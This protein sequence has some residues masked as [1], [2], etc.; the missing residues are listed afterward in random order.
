V[1]RP[2]TAESLLADLAARRTALTSL[3]ARAQV[4]SG[5]RG[6]WAREAFAVRRPDAVRIDVLAPFGVALALGAQGARLWAYRP[7]DATRYDGAATA[8][9]LTRLL[10]VP[11]AVSDVVDIL[12]GLPPQRRPAGP[13]TLTPTA[14]GEYKL[15]V[16]HA[17]GA[18]TIWFAGDTLA[19]LRAEESGPHGVQ[20]RLVFSDY[21]AGFPYAI[22]LAAVGTAEARL[23][24]EAVEPNAAVD[25][26]LFVPP[27][28]PRVLPFEA[29]GPP[30]G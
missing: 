8:D 13:A 3:R 6:L 26:A 14:A 5:L 28:A 27:P 2:A 11:L 29:A 10:G 16:P 12:L 22:E 15:Q 24:Y 9:N 21:R 23:T 17:E 25:P 1:L 30:P 4:R 20:L 7:A 19:V 18:Q